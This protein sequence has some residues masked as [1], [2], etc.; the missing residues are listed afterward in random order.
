MIDEVDAAYLFT[1]AV[2]TMGRAD[3]AGIIDRPR[4]AVPREVI[5]CGDLMSFIPI[6]VALLHDKFPNLSD[7]DHL[8]ELLMSRFTETASGRPH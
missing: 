2:L 1:Q 3:E 5:N 7:P 6:L 8:S 4:N